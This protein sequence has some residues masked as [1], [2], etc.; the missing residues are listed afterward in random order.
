MVSPANS[1]RPQNKGNRRLDFAYSLAYYAI[2]IITFLCI[3]NLVSK[4]V[5]PRSF[6][7]VPL[8]SVGDVLSD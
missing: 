8:F 2:L 7:T 3:I 5:A 6:D 4:F 1:V